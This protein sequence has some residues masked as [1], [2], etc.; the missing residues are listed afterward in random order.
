[1]NNK[2]IV[3]SLCDYTGIFTKPWTEAGY[4]ALHVDPQRENNG[5]ILEM[6]PSIALAIQSGQVKF[7]AGFP[8][9]TELAV[10]GAAHFAKKAEKD[11]HF[12]AKAALIAEQ[13]RMIGELSGAPWFLENPVSVLASIMGKP[14]FTFN[15]YEFGGYLPEDDKHPEWPEY[16][17]PRDAY[18]KK[19]CLWSGGGFE[20]P[21]RKPVEVRPGYSDQHHKLGGKSLRTKNIRSATPRGFA[22]AIFEKYGDS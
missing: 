2:G 9:C 14:Q 5:T 15:P 3:I 13:C 16:I 7:V 10:S 4:T 6:S 17:A 11:K 1:M 22:Q 21:E 19:T 18:P 8:P 20:L 12:Q